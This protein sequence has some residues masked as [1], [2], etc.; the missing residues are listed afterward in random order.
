MARRAMSNDRRRKSSSSFAWSK[1]E[2]L[3]IAAPTASSIM[4]MADAAGKRTPSE[5]QAS[6]MSRHVPTDLGEIG[7]AGA[8]FI[9]EFAVEHHHEPVR[10]FEQFI[11]VFRSEEH[12]SE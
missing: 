12:T 6:S 7:L 2:V 8:R 4:Q 5:L 9:D 10:E 3:L 11:E 1:S